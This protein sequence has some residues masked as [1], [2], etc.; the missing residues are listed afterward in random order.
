MLPLFNK[1]QEIAYLFLMT[2]FRLDGEELLVA[3]TAE[4]VLWVIDFVSQ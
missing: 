2:L 3:N 1:A 4:N